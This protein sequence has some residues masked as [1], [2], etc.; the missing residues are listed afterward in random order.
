MRDGL[1][2]AEGSAIFAHAPS[3]EKDG[4]GAGKLPG[5]MC[6]EADACVSFPARGGYLGLVFLPCLTRNRAHVPSFPTP[7]RE[8]PRPLRL[9]LRRARTGGPRAGTLRLLPRA[10][11]R[12]RRPRALGFSRLRAR[13]AAHPV[14]GRG[15]LFAGA[16]RR[17]GPRDDARIRA[18]VRGTSAPLPRHHHAGEPRPPRR[19][20]AEQ[21][22]PRRRGGAAGGRGRSAH[23][24][25]AGDP[26]AEL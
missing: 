25:A 2:R 12:S 21:P 14:C 26:V 17:L 20:P 13:H 16:R 23:R 4:G 7:F 10:P 19:D 15:G 22:P 8:P 3:C 24:R 11:V 6:A 9:C 18:D 5:E 1:G